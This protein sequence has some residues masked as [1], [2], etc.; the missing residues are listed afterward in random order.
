MKFLFYNFF[1]TITI[2]VYNKITV[3]QCRISVLKTFRYGSRSKNFDV[4]NIYG[5]IRV[6]KELVIDLFNSCG[7]DQYSGL[8]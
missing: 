8:V 1:N 5:V 7:F 4:K 6:I 2:E 3:Q